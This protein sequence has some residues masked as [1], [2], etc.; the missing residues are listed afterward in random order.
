MYNPIHSNCCLS[1]CIININN[2]VD[3]SVAVSLYAKCKFCHFSS[4]EGTEQ[5]SNK[6]EMH[7]RVF[8]LSAL[9]LGG[10]TAG[11]TLKSG[12]LNCTTFWWWYYHYVIGE[13]HINAISYMGIGAIIILTFTIIVGLMVI[14]M[15]LKYMH[16][17]HDL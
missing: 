8:F 9:L 10:T 14:F 3:T 7:G 2:R 13:N 4:D 11:L 5:T 12:I 1:L 15:A 6:L 16:Q 17:F